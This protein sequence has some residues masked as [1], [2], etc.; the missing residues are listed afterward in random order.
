[1]YISCTDHLQFGTRYLAINPG[2]ICK[3]IAQVYTKL[4]LQKD[5]SVILFS[6]VFLFNADFL[7]KYLLKVFA[8]SIQFQGKYVSIFFSL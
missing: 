8:H 6:Y 4:I 7:G 2:T 5:H 3:D 1:M